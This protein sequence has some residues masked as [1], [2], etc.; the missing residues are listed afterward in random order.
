MELPVFKSVVGLS[1]AE[2]EAV[3][4]QQKMQLVIAQE[5]GEIIRVP[6]RQQHEMHVA[7][8][9]GVVVRLL[10]PKRPAK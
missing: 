2:A 1:V 10:S 5:D 9:N 6:P 3:A 7:V 4:A 8:E